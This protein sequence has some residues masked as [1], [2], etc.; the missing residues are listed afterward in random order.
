MSS[1]NEFLKL[2][3]NEFASVAEDGVTAGDVSGWVDSGSYA[4]NALLSGDIYKGFPGNKIVI[5]SGE[6]SVGKSYFAL[7]AA[8]NFLEQN[9]DGIVI[10]F[11][12][13]SA[14]T[15]DMLIEREIDVKRFGVVPVSTVQQFKTQALRVVDNYEKQPKKDRQ[16][17]LFI[18]DSLGML[19][20]DKEMVD[21]AEGKDTRDMT[22][23]Q[24]IKAAF[25][26]LTLKLGRAGIPMLVTNHVY[27]DVGGGP[28][29]AK[30]QAG[31][32]A[33]V[34]AS[35]TILT[36]SKAKDRDATT[37][38]VTG[39]IIT[40]TATKSRFTK[41]NSKVKCLIRFDG[42]LDRYF[43]MLE[44]AEEAGV[45]KKVSTRYELEDGTKLFG[46]NIMENPEKYFTSDVLERINDYVKRKF[47]YG[48]G[49]DQTYIDESPEEEQDKGDI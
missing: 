24:L 2:T 19:S 45:F 4:F 10:M 41:E 29:A 46:K 49:T 26:V 8:K 21:S 31:G 48:S 30:K 43:G 13:E 34:Y 35:S 25:R 33:A 17:I 16:P 5:L 11:E 12:T 15:K 7:A 37:N 27:E 6:P 42:G 20:T 3:G 32:S 1:I 28:Y 22:R 36:L 47:C 39:V 14:L 9:K 18:L 40:A 38:E 23:A 44:L